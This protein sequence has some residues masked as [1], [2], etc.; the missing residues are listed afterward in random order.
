M[1]DSEGKHKICRISSFFLSHISSLNMRECGFSCL[2]LVYLCKIFM[3]CLF[4]EEL[5]VS[6]FYVS[7]SNVCFL[8]FSSGCQLWLTIILNLVCMD[9]FVLFFSP[10]C[11]VDCGPASLSAC[12]VFV[13]V[14]DIV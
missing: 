14:P 6:V 7:I 11:R 4:N 9:A 13:C 1:S 10:A 2:N 5:H 12:T 3:M 8:F